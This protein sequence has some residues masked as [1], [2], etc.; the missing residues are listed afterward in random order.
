MADS[1][2]L[3]TGDGSTVTFSFTFEYLDSSDIYVTVD[4]QSNTDWSFDTTTD[5]TSLTFNT[6]PADGAEILIYR[7]TDLDQMEAVF[8]AG[9]AIR[10]KDLNTDYDQLRLAIQES[11]EY[12]PD[13]IVDDQLDPR[14][15]QK[16]GETIESTDTWSED[17]T[18]VGTTK[19]IGN[20]VRSVTDSSSSVTKIIAGSNVTISPT[21]GQGNVTISA[22]STGGANYKGTIDM[23][24]AAPEAPVNGDFYVNTT[25][26]TADAS[27]TGI[28]GDDVTA[29]ARVVYNGGTSEW[30][31]LP[32]QATGVQSVEAGSDITVNNS[33]AEKPVVSVTTNA[34]ARPSDLTSFISD[35]PSDNK[36]YVRKDAAWYDADQKY[37]TSNSLNNY[38]TQTQGDARYL[39]LNDWSSITART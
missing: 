17:D 3:Y 4:D 9:S 30:D 22:S 27:W 19:A 16:E 32:A 39:P 7:S 23:T 21:S 37:L 28:G 29:G 8:A 2:N 38:L 36:C 18:H 1:F 25:A 24:Q 26:G 10:A 6:A 14:Y 33:D 31:L 15:W 11:K 20:F 35:A 13:V 12:I 5:P 34:F